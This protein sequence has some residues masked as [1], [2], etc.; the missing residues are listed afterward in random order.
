MGDEGDDVVEGGDG[1]DTLFGGDGDD[2]LYGD[3]DQDTISGGQGNDYLFAGDGVSN[4]LKGDQGDDTLVG[5]DEGSDDP[6]PQDNIL[7][8]DRLS[9]DEGDDTILGLGGS[10]IID[11]GTG[12]NTID[13]GVH[14]DI[15]TNGT[16]LPGVADFQLPSGPDRRGRFSQLS[17]SASFGGLSNVGGFEE[18]V[19]VDHSGVYVAWVDWRNGNSEIYVAHHPHGVGQWSALAGF[20]NFDS[21]SGGGISNDENQSRRPTLLKTESSDSLVVAWTSIAADGTSN[22]E[23]ARQD[24]AWDRLVNPAQSGRADHAR[25]VQHSDFSGLLFWVETNPV[26]GQRIVKSSQYVYSETPRVETF[27]TEQSIFIPS[28]GRNLQSYDAA[29]MEF[30]AVVT[31]SSTDGIDHDIVVR[32]DRAVLRDESFFLPGVP[33]VSFREYVSGR[34]ETIH[35]ITDD[36]TL[37]PTIGIQYLDQI[38]SVPGEIE[39]IYNV[40]VAWETVSSR[41]NQVD[42]LVLRVDPNLPLVVQPMVPQYQQD[43]SPRFGAQTVS[44]TLGYADKPDLAMGFSGTYLGWRDDGVFGGDG[45]S[46]IYVMGR[47]Y[48]PTLGDF[49]LSEE[50]PDEASG[51]G[52]AE[53]DSESLLASYIPVSADIG[54]SLRDLELSMVEDFFGGGS[55]VVLWNEARSTSSPNRNNVYLRTSLDGLEGV[56][57]SRLL[58]KFGQSVLNVLENDRGLF[59]EFLPRLTHF[60]GHELQFLPEK[61]DEVIVS[62]LLGA[63][64]VISA[65][66]RISYDPN[67]AVAFRN[68]KR[69]EFIKESF[70]YR[71]DNGI[72]RAEAIVEF[73]VFGTNV[74]R[75]ERDP[76][77]VND[78]GFTG[79]L[80]VLLLINDINTNGSRRLDD[81]GPGIKKFLDVDDDGFILPLDVLNVIN[82]INSRSG[83]EGENARVVQG[84]GLAYDELTDW[85]EKQRRNQR[86]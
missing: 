33:N 46:S 34:W 25:F 35:Q 18:T 81:I 74:W 65:N 13:G 5:S 77:D 62:S 38:G 71:V 72:H 67:G 42:G 41:E 17:R 54:G 24:Q 30:Q 52:I 6:K 23:V 11:G 84:L 7:F 51:P 69:T 43:P 22:I 9:G 16:D 37:E 59:G 28:A 36:N 14:T 27:L 15:V 75:N 83:S 29:S 66:G 21:A 26:S 2:A 70:V 45:R 63:R 39:L 32:K 44:D 68:L 61:D 12:N 47:F 85:Q 79:P 60:D 1:D 58:R 56:D 76:F 50:F 20:G 4:T 49:I 86:R 78:D 8:G 73:V 31:I 57:D 64:I 82:L 40:A 55:L 48:D 53:S 3:A 80:D 10:D 19:Y